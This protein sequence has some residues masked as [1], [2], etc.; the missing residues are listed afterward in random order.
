MFYR[1]ISPIKRKL[2]LMKKA[3]SKK[4]NLKATRRVSVYVNSFIDDYVTNHENGGGLNFDQQTTLMNGLNQLNRA[5]VYSDYKNIMNSRYIKN[6]AVEQ[7]ILKNK[8]DGKALEI[9]TAQLKQINKNIKAIDEVVNKY[10][11]KIDK[12]KELV[13]KYPKHQSRKGILTESIS[14]I[15]YMTGMGMN[16]RPNVFGYT[17]LPP[18]TE[19]LYRQSEIEAKVA[20]HEKENEIHEKENGEPLY[21]SKIWI[22]TGIGKTTRHESNDGKTVGIDELFEI[23]NDATGEVDM[24]RHPLDPNIGFSNSGICY[25]EMEYSKDPPT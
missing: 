8:A 9:T 6:D 11:V 23:V 16:I 19:F 25:C 3:R 13:N 15:N 2:Y 14:N 22:W 4:R 5:K 10:E 24:M 18:M 1:E 17:D 20:L 21:Q 7:L 12:Y